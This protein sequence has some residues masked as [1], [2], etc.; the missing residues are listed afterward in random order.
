MKFF[1]KFGPTKRAETTAPEQTLEVEAG[2]QER[3]EAAAI[4]IDAEISSGAESAL[5]DQQVQEALISQAP[6]EQQDQL[7]ADLQT[8]AGRSGIISAIVER[9]KD[10]FPAAFGGGLAGTITMGV[11]KSAIRNGIRFGIIGTAGTGWLAAIGVGGLAGGFAGGIVEGVREYI[12]R[13]YRFNP[14][15]VMQQ[16][17]EETDPQKRAAIVRKAEEAYKQ[18]RYT[19]DAQEISELRETLINARAA[20]NVDNL[21]PEEKAGLDSESKK[22]LYILNRK[23]TDRMRLSR[24]ERKVS[25]KSLKAVKFTEEKIEK[26][27][28][29]DKALVG[30]AM[31]KG[32]LTGFATGSLGGLVHNYFFKTEISGGSGAHDATKELVVPKDKQV[33]EQMI[34]ERRQALIDRTEKLQTIIE[35]SNETFTESSY[36]G[37]VKEGGNITTALREKMN[38]VLSH[39]HDLHVLN[40]NVPDP[41]ENLTAEKMEWVVAHGLMPKGAPDLVQPGYE[42]EFTG[43]QVLEGLKQYDELSAEQKLAWAEVLKGKLSEKTAKMMVTLT[44]QAESGQFALPKELAG[45]YAKLNAENESLLEQVKELL[46][47]GA[48]ISRDIINPGSEKVVEKAAGSFW[49]VAATVAVEAPADLYWSRTENRKNFYQT[50]PSE[51]PEE[52]LEPAAAD[53]IVPDV[54][55]VEPSQNQAEVIAAAGAGTAAVTVEANPDPGAIVPDAVEPQPSVISTP[56][57]IENEPQNPL[58]QEAAAELAT[59]LGI[60]NVVF[61]ESL[62]KYRPE[63]IAVLAQ[64]VSDFLGTIPELAEHPE[65]VNALIVSNNIDEKTNLVAGKLVLKRDKFF[66]REAVAQ[67]EAEWEMREMILDFLEARDPESGWSK[68]QELIGKYEKSFYIPEDFWDSPDRKK[69]IAN[70]EMVIEKLGSDAL[71]RID[72][73]EFGTGARAEFVTPSEDDKF[74]IWIPLSIARFDEGQINGWVNEIRQQLGLEK[75]AFASV[76]P[77]AQELGGNKN[78]PPIDESEE[79][80]SSTANRDRIYE[81]VKDIYTRLSPELQSKVKRIVLAAPEDESGFGY[82]FHADAGLLIIPALDALNNKDQLEAEI[83]EQ[84]SEGVSAVDKGTEATGEL[85]AEE[86]EK[87]LAASETRGGALNGETEL[88]MAEL[89]RSGLGPKRSAEMYGEKMYFSGSIDMGGDYTAVLGYIPDGNKF[90]VRGYYKSKSGGA[91]WRYLPAYDYFETRYAK[92]WE[93]DDTLTASARKNSV[94]APGLME[95]ELSSIADDP[96][97]AIDIEG[98]KAKSIFRRTAKPMYIRDDQTYQ[99]VKVEKPITIEGNINSGISREKVP[100]TELKI[101]NE[102]QRPNYENKLKSWTTNIIDPI[103]KRRFRAEVDLYKSND[104]SLDY[105]FI[106]DI[107]NQR[108][109]IGMIDDGTE[110]LTSVG[111]KPK[112]VDGG[113]LTTPVVDYAQYTGSYGVNKG[114]SKYLDMWDNYLRHV[115]EIQNYLKYKLGD[116]YTPP[117]PPKKQAGTTTEKIQPIRRAS[118]R[119]VIPIEKP[120]VASSA[121]NTPT[122]QE[123][124]PL[125]KLEA[126]IGEMEVS[127]KIMEDSLRDDVGI[128]FS[129]RPLFE[130]LRTNRKYGKEAAE[131]RSKIL[132]TVLNVMNDIYTNQKK[133]AGLVDKKVILYSPKEKVTSQQRGD[134]VHI[135]VD[136]KNKDKIIKLLRKAR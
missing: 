7:R 124:S 85:S 126:E 77:V 135:K 51:E 94:I 104:G 3:Q 123:L 133:Y 35:K 121:E 78:F 45:E 47:Q 128:D 8:S 57:P 23:F 82:G 21:S 92:G 25:N 65:R 88:D 6:P 76:A 117:E 102:G 9:V 19:G 22:T 105:M 99:G 44:S 93:F 81:V 12:R 127:Y 66:K 24:E 15:E 34:E 69:A 125:Q 96:S 136:T 110:K 109:W 129:S 11:L 103:T 74:K 95:A 26:L 91:V 97:M 52:I 32:F 56:E 60:G 112:W 83:I 115:P 53:E 43:K 71:E 48:K 29:E 2:E 116:T 61:D 64:K 90:K 13:K 130:Y 10:R 134:I 14:L 31:G 84:L 106:F 20:F 80:E 42:V 59:K 68:V 27:S 86:I 58:L 72:V 73:F 17:R 114:P 70:G 5:D 67:E 4:D 101:T 37:T 39:Y 98:P 111:L 38:E 50:K 49:G 113:D 28:A 122:A 30:K 16:I 87:V 118:D 132:K 18:A 54:A 33:I 63:Q 79:F 107:Q 120:Q 75:I 36:A 40:P 119:I 1:E 131:E 62:G 108:A 41:S 46:G 89:I 100:P 55:S